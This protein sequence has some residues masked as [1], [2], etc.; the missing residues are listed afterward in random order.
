MVGFSSA[1]GVR[2]VAGLI[3][4]LTGAFATLAVKVTVKS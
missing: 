3:S 4:S 1:G 2:V